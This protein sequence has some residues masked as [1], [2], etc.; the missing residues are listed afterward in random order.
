MA[1]DTQTPEAEDK[2]VP[3]LSRLRAPA[4][5]THRRRRV[6]R[7]EGSGLG[8]TCGKGQKGQKSRG[9][10]KKPHFEGGQMPLQRR[11]PKVGFNNIF[12]AKIAT[13]N[14]GA[15]AVFEA[16]EVVDQDALRKRRLVRGDIDGVKILGNGELDKALTLKVNAISASAREKL[17]KAGGSVELLEPKPRGPKPR[18]K[19]SA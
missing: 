13:V 3:I 16:G 11:L 6:G 19:K 7:G 10:L 1:E 4:G 5:A 9:P 2:N 15:L 8:K 17:E 12:A 18:D 14:V